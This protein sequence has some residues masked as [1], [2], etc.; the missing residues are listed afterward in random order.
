MKFS[1]LCFWGNRFSETRDAVMLGKWFTTFR[2][3]VGFFFT[4]PITV[5]FSQ[6][7]HSRTASHPRWHE[8]KVLSEIYS[9]NFIR[10]YS[11]ICSAEN[12]KTLWKS[13]NNWLNKHKQLWESQVSLLE[14]FANNCWE[15]AQFEFWIW[16]TRTAPTSVGSFFFFLIPFCWWCCSR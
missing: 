14:K 15:V 13:A 4:S 11:L 6:T 8:S 12:L 5:T 2:R 16:W 7:R 1:Q 10:I 3:N 9:L